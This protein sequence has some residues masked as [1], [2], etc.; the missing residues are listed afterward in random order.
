M[1]VVEVAFE[2]APEQEA[3]VRAMVD[4]ALASGRCVGPDGD[5]STWEVLD[6]EP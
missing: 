4:A 6:R 3:E 2:T 1:L 5:T